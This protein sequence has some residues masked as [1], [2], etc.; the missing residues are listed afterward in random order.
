MQ[1]NTDNEKTNDLLLEQKADAARGT[2]LG[3]CGQDGDGNEI[4]LNLNPDE[5]SGSKKCYGIWWDGK[6][7]NNLLFLQ[8]HS[9]GDASQRICRSR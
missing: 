6:R 7:Q 3:T 9:P 1:K 2:I 4:V 5:A 8:L